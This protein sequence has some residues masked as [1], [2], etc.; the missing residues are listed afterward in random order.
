MG[1]LKSSRSLRS[2]VHDV[3]VPTK[4]LLSASIQKAKPS[5]LQQFFFSS[6]ALLLVLAMPF[7]QI[8]KLSTAILNLVDLVHESRWVLNFLFPD[9]CDD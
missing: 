4:G 2:E 7:S 8:Q 5:Q 9:V 1:S 3:V 6:L